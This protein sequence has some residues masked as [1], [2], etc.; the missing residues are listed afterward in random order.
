MIELRKLSFRYASRKPFVLQDLSL[1]FGPGQT[2]GLFGKNG[3][4]KSSLLLLMAGLLRPTGGEALIDGRAATDRTPRQLTEIFVVPEQLALP[5][6]SLRRFVAL[7][8]PFYPRF[9][10]TIFETCLRQFELTDEL[11]FNT[12]ST[13]QQKKA[14]LSFALAAGTPY[15][16]LDEPTNGLDIPSKAQFRKALAASMDET[17]TIV[18]S[19]HQVH[20]I[21]HMVDRIVMLGDRR[22][23]ADFTV[24]ELCRRLCFEQYPFGGAPQDALYVEPSLAGLSVIRP[25][26]DGRETDFDLEILFKAL[27]EHP[28][29]LRS[30]AAQVPSVLENSHDA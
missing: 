24:E 26:V 22:L 19:T 16:L 30:L 20:D 12:L 17:R 29:L 7:H 28:D 5:S 13:G 10:T 8:R 2:V 15:L 25:N 9:S 14:F 18:I 1:D 6:I 4:G 3:V 11:R 21:E 27:V 23:V